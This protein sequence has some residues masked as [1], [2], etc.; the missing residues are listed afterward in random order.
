MIAVLALAATATQIPVLIG[1]AEW[2]AAPAMRP[3]GDP[4]R[5]DANEEFRS[6]LRSN[7]CD[8]HGATGTDFKKTTVRYAAFL[9]PDGTV[10]RLLIE[11]VGCRPLEKLV[12]AMALEMTTKVD[13]PGGSEA[14]WYQAAVRFDGARW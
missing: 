4:S 14:A 6:I 11:D 10:E 12:G 8:L 7:E 3:R 2:A 9:K 1:K 5:I 13:P